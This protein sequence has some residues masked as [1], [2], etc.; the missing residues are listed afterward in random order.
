MCVMGFT[1]DDKEFLSMAVNSILILI[2]V[3]F[4]ATYRGYGWAQFLLEFWF[5]WTGLAFAYVIK[6][7]LLEGY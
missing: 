1:I 6:E 4:L 2:V 5:V 3:F 7:V